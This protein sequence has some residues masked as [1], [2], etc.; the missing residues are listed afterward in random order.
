[1]IY[2]KDHVLSNE[3]IDQLKPFVEKQDWNSWYESLHI[4]I[5]STHN[6]VQKEIVTG[7]HG[8]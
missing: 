7:K 2:I 4:E 5:P 8:L 3:D 1:M 6:I